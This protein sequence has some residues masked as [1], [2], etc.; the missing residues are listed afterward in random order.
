MR[1][2][3]MLSVLLLVVGCGSEPRGANRAT[4]S[5]R[6]ASP[7]QAD[8]EFGARCGLDYHSLNEEK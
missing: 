6:D 3:I 8:A 4:E 5:A 2:L 1:T 7:A